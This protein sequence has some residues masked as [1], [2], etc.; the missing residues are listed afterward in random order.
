VPEGLLTVYNFEVH[1]I[2]SG[3]P[4]DLGLMR[5]P[6][7]AFSE[8][9]GLEIT[10]EQTSLREGGYHEGARQLVGRT[11]HPPLVLKR[12][13][14][15]DSGFWQWIQSCL[16]GTY[17]LPYIGGAVLVFGPGADR[18]STMPAVWRFTN[19]I[20]TKVT[21][22]ALAAAGASSVPIEELHVVHEGLRRLS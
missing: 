7:G 16:N 1:L 20:A 12:G 15:L 21:G 17:P 14:S 8:V 11:T 4:G 9:T 2:P 5:D 22:A 19:G 10:L 18:L 6:K 3:L 13:M